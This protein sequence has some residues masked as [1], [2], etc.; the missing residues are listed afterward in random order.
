[1]RPGLPPRTL[2]VRIKRRSDQALSDSRPADVQAHSDSDATSPDFT[3]TSTQTG[4]NLGVIA[5]AE[6]QTPSNIT[7]PVDEARYARLQRAMEISRT[8]VFY[9]DIVNATVEFDA[10]SCRLHGYPE[11]IA[12][13]PLNFETLGERMAPNA[14]DKVVTDAESGLGQSGFYETTYEVMWLDGSQHLVHSRG[15][16]EFDEHGKPVAIFGVNIEADAFGG[17]GEPNIAIHEA[18]RLQGKHASWVLYIKKNKIVGSAQFAEIYGTAENEISIKEFWSLVPKSDHHVVWEALEKASEPGLQY[19]CCHRLQRRD[20]GEVRWLL[21]RGRSIVGDAGEVERF[22][23]TVEDVTEQK[24][25]EETSLESA[26]TFRA[27][28]QASPGLIFRAS[29]HGMITFFNEPR[30]T[31]FSGMSPGSWFG[32]GW[33]RAF[34]P[35]DRDVAR[36][37]WFEAVASREGFQEE[38]RWRRRDGQIRWVLLHAIPVMRQGEV[39]GFVGTGTDITALRVAERERATL[40]IALAESQKLEAIGTLASGVAHDFNNMLAAVR[41]YLELATLRL[42]T[43]STVSDYL[44]RALTAVDEASEVTGGLLTFARGGGGQR[45]AL[46]LNQ[47]INENL[48]LLQQLV[49]ASIELVTELPP[50]DITVLGN[51]TQ[52][53]QVLTNLVINARD[54]MPAGGRVLVTLGYASEKVAVLVVKDE[55]KGMTAESLERAFDPFFTTKAHGEGSGLGLSVVHGIVNAHGGS[56]ELRS[57]LNHGTEVEIRLPITHMAAQD[58]LTYSF[59]Q[60]SPG[61]RVLFVED[62]PL[63][64]ESCALRLEASGFDVVSVEDGEEAMVVVQETEQPF[65]VAM[66]DVDLPGDDGVTVASQL[67]EVSPDMSVVYVTG[68]IQNRALKRALKEDPVLAKPIDFNELFDTIQ[69]L[70]TA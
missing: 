68:N 36:R 16:W 20:T 38:F 35:A 48:S 28:S 19:E 55:G 53:K 54:A 40:Q 51:A 62:N 34:H 63:V 18:S 22:V 69:S 21:Q 30:W 5:V 13:S 47:V 66:L 46:A 59:P 32:E 17:I 25:A 24:R 65:A 70:K 64:R 26:R 42:D 15:V 56:I 12:G 45:R 11:S 29:R 14:L 6:N 23:G 27:L 31:E 3:Q 58:P 9:V 52:L 39:A 37:A 43:E 50:Q 44:T 60:A 33:F 67:R 8:G 41:G 1:M 61:G 7:D 2:D 4:P 49:S 10:R 57:K